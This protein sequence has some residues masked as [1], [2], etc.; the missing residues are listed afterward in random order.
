M[1]DERLFDTYLAPTTRHNDIKAPNRELKT[2]NSE[3]TI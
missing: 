1:T 2:Q 3:L